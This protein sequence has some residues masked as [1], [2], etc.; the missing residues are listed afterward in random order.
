MIAKY[1]ASLIAAVL[2]ASIACTT[3]QFVARSQ[4]LSGETVEETWPLILTL[5]ADS[6]HTYE[7]NSQMQAGLEK[8]ITFV[9]QGPMRVDSASVDV[10]PKKVSWREGNQEIT[11]DGASLVAH[12]KWD[13]P[14]DSAD[15]ARGDIRMV[16]PIQHV[17]EPNLHSS[18]YR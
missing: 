13:T 10:T 4:V 16:F 14:A 1:V 5:D 6:E 7:I 3:L 18:T 2:L 17:G 8:G 9:A 12:V 11:S 15:D